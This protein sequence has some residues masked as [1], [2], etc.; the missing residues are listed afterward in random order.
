MPPDGTSLLIATGLQTQGESGVIVQRGERMAPSG[1]QCKVSFEIHL[2]QIVGPRMLES[3]PSLVFD[4]L[5]RVDQPMSMEDV[6]DRAGRRQVL[7]PQ[8]FETG[9][10]L[11]PAPGGMGL[12]HLDDLAFDPIGGS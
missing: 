12:S 8:R 6:G 1:R 2:P 10:N 11:A 7:C 9:S 5:I 3:N 4:A